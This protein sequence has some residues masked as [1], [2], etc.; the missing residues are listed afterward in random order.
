MSWQCH[1]CGSTNDN[2]ILR[3]V[4][5]YELDRSLNDEQGSLQ[6]NGKS[7]IQEIDWHAVTIDESS[8]RTGLTSID[9]RLRDKIPFLIFSR[10]IYFFSWIALIGL[11]ILRIIKLPIEPHPQVINDNFFQSSVLLFIQILCG[12]LSA[13]M[14]KM[15]GKSPLRWFFYGLIPIGLLFRGVLFVLTF[16]YSVYDL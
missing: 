16:V 11:S 14:A 6:Q 2:S 9:Q 12:I 7:S 10:P 5:G 1:V 3:C 8:P 13:N 15:A 4:C